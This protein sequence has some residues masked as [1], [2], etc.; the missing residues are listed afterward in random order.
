MSVGVD[1]SDVSSGDKTTIIVIGDRL[2]DCMDAKSLHSTD[3]KD[4]DAIDLEEAN[5]IIADIRANFNK[6]FYRMVRDVIRH[7]LPTKFDL[8]CIE[9]EEEPLTFHQKLNHNHIHGGKGKR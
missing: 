6:F 5:K 2:G 3:G 9:P 4:A 7:S 8:T 1:K